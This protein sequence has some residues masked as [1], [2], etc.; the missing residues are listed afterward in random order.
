MK[1]NKVAVIGYGNTLRGDDGI[2]IVAVREVKGCVEGLNVDT[3][4]YHQL[5]IEVLPVLADYEKIIFIDCSADIGY[6]E[7]F[8]RQIRPDESLS[9]GMTHHITPQQIL[10]LLEIL[11]NKSPECYVCEVGGRVFDFGT[12]VS[13]QVMDSTPQVVEECIR[14]ITTSRK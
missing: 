2:G 12:D 11:Y 8:C 3:Y 5:N 10:Q 1:N 9:L 6:G 13:M 14:L 7:V 4:E